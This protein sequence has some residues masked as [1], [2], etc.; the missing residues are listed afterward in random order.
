MPT[1]LLIALPRFLD[2]PTALDVGT[3]SRA[4]PFG[5]FLLVQYTRDVAWFSKVM[6]LT[7]NL[8]SEKSAD[9]SGPRV[10]SLIFL[11]GYAQNAEHTGLMLNSKEAGWCGKD[12]YRPKIIIIKV[13]NV[14][15]RQSGFDP[16]TFTFSENSNY[17]RKSLLEV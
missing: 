15:K 10:E 6:R 12:E 5:S 17:G 9:T 7:E 16:I 8:T 2:V 13:E 3:L 1:V 11:P 14:F 4:I